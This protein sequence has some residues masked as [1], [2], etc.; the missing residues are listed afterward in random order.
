MTLLLDASVW[1][2]AQDL[3]DAEHHSATTL[4]STAGAVWALDLTRLE[5]ANTALRRAATIGDPSLLLEILE[6]RCSE[7]APVDRELARRAAQIAS[8]HGLSAYDAAYVAAARSHRCVLVST[9]VRDL[10]SRDLAILPST[11]LERR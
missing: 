11:A 7:I 1:I 4:L 9:D 2:T 5:V 8:E 10:V 6:T 3:D